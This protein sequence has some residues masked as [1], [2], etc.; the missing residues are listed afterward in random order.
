MEWQDGEVRGYHDSRNEEAEEEKTA[1]GSELGLRVICELLF[2]RDINS[3]IYRFKGS[4]AVAFE[5]VDGEE[6]IIEIAQEVAEVLL[7][8][9]LGQQFRLDQLVTQ[10]IFI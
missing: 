10:K 6:S 9:L 8:I 5:W 1:H 3:S 7:H 4:R 2:C